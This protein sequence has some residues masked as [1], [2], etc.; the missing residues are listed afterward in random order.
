MSA[1]R[2]IGAGLAIAAAG[3]LTTTGLM[4][5]AGV[6]HV[7]GVDLQVGTLLLGALVFMLSAYVEELVFRR[8]LLG[9]LLRVTGSPWLALASMAAVTGVFHLVT[10]AHT[11]AISVAS[12]T[13][14]GVMYGVAYLRTGRIWLGL[15]V[16]IGWNFFQGTVLGFP[17]SGTDDYSGALLQVHTSGPA[18]LSGGG[19][20]PEGSVF[21]LVGRVVIIAL[22]LLATRGVTPSASPGRPHPARG[23]SSSCRPAARGRSAPRSRG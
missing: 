4:A 12:S 1:L 21:S 19:Y 17:V 5:L 10:T 7:D 23:T 9:G 22:I 2:S 16:H 14:G 15:G 11:T 13:L 18:W 3:M 8:L 6:A 20:G